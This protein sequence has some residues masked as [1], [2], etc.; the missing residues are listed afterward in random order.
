MAL[1]HKIITQTLITVVLIGVFLF[2]TNSPAS[3]SEIP[4]QQLAQ[5]PC[6]MKLE[7]TLKDA[8]R[9]STAASINDIFTSI[10]PTEELKCNGAGTKCESKFAF[11]C[12]TGWKP[13]KLEGEN[14]TC[15]AKESST[16]PSFN[17]VLTFPN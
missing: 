11:P 1:L 15:C 13:C 9:S 5:M 3:A 12:P 10:P 4:S 6:Q 8:N 7:F 16:N 14:K 2:Q 17:I